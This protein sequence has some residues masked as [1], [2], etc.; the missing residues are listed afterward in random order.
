MGNLFVFDLDG[1]III[2]NQ[3]LHPML[4]EI[5]KELEKKEEKIVFA[6]SRSL[7]GVKKV[8][9]EQLLKFPLILCN[10]AFAVWDNEIVSEGSIPKDVYEKISY[11]L[12]KN[13][14][15]FYL[16]MGTEIFIPKDREH[17]FLKTL[18]EEAK[19]EKIYHELSE[20]KSKVYKIGVVE[21][22]GSDILKEIEDISGKSKIY[23][24]MDRTVDIVPENC[25]KWKMLQKLKLTSNGKKI[26]TFGNDANDMEMI[27]DADIGVAVCSSN[28]ELCEVADVQVFDNSP[29][30]LVKKIEDICAILK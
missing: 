14:I 25:S 15:S 13:N 11:Y 7:R 29:E 21:T 22:I 5:L 10:G 24:H 9:P 1:T 17:D 28:K 3:M 4:Y 8:L 30:S 19:N 20:I 2:D 18:K 23:Q 6:T 12:E 26:V 27:Q 16:D